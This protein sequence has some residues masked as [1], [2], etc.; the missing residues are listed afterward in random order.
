MTVQE[1]LDA[2]PDRTL[3]DKP[4]FEATVLEEPFAVV[5]LDFIDESKNPFSTELDEEEKRGDS[6][7]L[8]HLSFDLRTAHFGPPEYLTATEENANSF[9]A[10]VSVFFTSD[11]YLKTAEETYEKV[12]GILKTKFGETR[13]TSR[14]GET[15]PVVKGYPS[16]SFCITYTSD[17]DTTGSVPLYSQRIFPTDDNRYVII[18]HFIFTDEDSFWHS[19]VYSLI[20][21]DISKVK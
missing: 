6:I 19:V 16:G 3:I 18:N 4:I 5:A 14:R 9:L 1:V 13:Y 21:V 20:P 11:K 17:K 12:E 10:I 2:N 7:K 8:G 15:L